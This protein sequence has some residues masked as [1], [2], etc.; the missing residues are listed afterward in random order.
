MYIYIIYWIAT[1]CEKTEEKK[2]DVTLKY[3]VRNSTNYNYAFVHTN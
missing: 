1:L 3:Q 2:S